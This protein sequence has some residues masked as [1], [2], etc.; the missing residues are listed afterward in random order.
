MIESLRAQTFT[1][2]EV[3]AVDDGSADA[4]GDILHAWAAGDPRVRT[5]TSSGNGIVD[6]LT[7]AAAHAR[8]ALLARMDA[9]DFA[10]PERLERQVALLDARPDIAACGTHVRYFPRELV[11]DGARRYEA[12]L[13]SLATPDELARDLFV[14]CPIA[15]PTLMLRRSAFDS[16]GGYQARDWPEDYDL[17]LRLAAAGAALA[18]V[19]VVLHAWRERPDRASR[20]DPRYSAGAFRRCKVHYLRPLRLYARNGVV[21][22]GAGRVGKLFARELLADGSTLR[23][24]V[25]L[26][27]RKIGQE[28]Y[29]VRVVAPAEV[30]R[31]PDAYVVAAVGSPGARA[32]IRAWLGSHGYAEPRDFCAVA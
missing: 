26:D 8:G 14:E 29:G 27:P 16:V 21:V 17:V 20:V 11:R 25:D 22:W 19:P 18:N 31:F 13:N 2:F 30:E 6:A 9:D 32:E 1:D 10:H 28:V 23:A 5:L 4:T 24:F 15:H 3:M 12:W 7:L